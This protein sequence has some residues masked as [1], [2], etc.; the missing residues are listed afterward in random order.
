MSDNRDLMFRYMAL[1]WDSSS[2]GEQRTAARL[3]LKLQMAAP[4]WQ[5]A[6]SCP[7]LSVYVAGVRPRVNTVH[8][9]AI[10]QGVVLGK[11]FRRSDLLQ[12]SASDASSDISLTPDDNAGILRS[13]G[14]SLIDRFWGRYIAILHDAAA[15]ETIIV[16][17]P[18]GTLPCQLL[19]HRGVNVVFSCMEDVLAL[20]PGLPAP[21]INW[22]YLRIHVASGLLECRETAING[23]VQLLSGE[24][25]CLRKETRTF[26]AYWSPV[27]VACRRWDGDPAGA[28]VALRR[29]V[30]ACVQSWAQCYG[31]LA[32]LLSGGIDSSIVLSCLAAGG[33]PP[34]KVTCINHHSPGSNSDER[35]YARLAA[36]RAGRPMV[37]CERDPNLRLSRIL[38][39]ARTA[40]PSYYL[41]RLEFDRLNTEVLAA[42]GASVVF[43]GGGGD[44]LFYEYRQW[45]PL[46]DY[47]RTRGVDS[48]LFRA[49]MDAARLGGVS[50]W[51]AFGLAVGERILPRDPRT[52]R[53]KYLELLNSDV[54]A[55]ARRDRRFVH[56]ALQ[57]ASGVPIG[58]LTQVMHVLYPAEYYDPLGAASSLELHN[59]LMSQPVI[60]LCLQLPTYVLTRGGRGRALARQAFAGD[61]PA[62]IRRRRSKGGMVEQATAIL[63]RN[64]DFV[65][66]ILLDGALVSR[67][68]LDRRKLEEVLSERPSPNVT[69][70]L[71]LHDYLG[72]EAW[73]SRWSSSQARAAA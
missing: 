21:T 36:A 17:D 13:R 38:D 8:L 34:L 42:H 32:M 60:E 23:V 51:R 55:E 59:P 65:R 62:E 70:L 71:E 27:D 68:V 61:L 40:S 14:R 10:D 69:P 30:R 58:K 45:W 48:G 39:I 50:V 47:L 63:Q 52:E 2:P 44:Q 46:A 12:P 35:M 6:L 11:L 56:P 73:L 19:Q 25:V 16:R 43:T 7:G 72:T 54:V 31:S 41:Q 18:T 33:S 15:G 24:A 66:G 57:S 26:H 1:C 53:G 37:E 5:K 3:A 4:A 29:T 20:M 22:D 67:G 64:L 28:A 9:L 49:A